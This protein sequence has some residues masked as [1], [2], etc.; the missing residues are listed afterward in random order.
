MKSEFEL[1]DELTT[2]FGKPQPPALGIGDDAAVF[3]AP[4]GM[5]LIWT[6][7][8]QI[9]NIHFRWNWL[10]PEQVG[11]R[12]ACQSLSDIAAMGG[13]PKYAMIS[14]HVPRPLFSKQ[15]LL[16]ICKG[17]QE[18][19]QKFHVQ[20]L[21]GNISQSPTLSIE[22]ALIGFIQSGK[23]LSRANAQVG[24]DVYVTGYP[25]SCAAALHLFKS[26]KGMMSTL[27][28]G[29]QKWR[30]PSPR[31]QE[32]LKLVPLAHAAIDI[33]DGV[34]QDANHIAKASQVTLDFYI[35]KFPC[36]EFLKKAA[37]TLEWPIEKFFFEPSDDYELLFTA[38]EDH[39]IKIQKDFGQKVTQV[40]KVIKGPGKVRIF[41][42]QREISYEGP[43]G[44][45]HF[46][47]QYVP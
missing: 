44:W 31:I 35:D 34:F 33:S 22:T 32:G 28:E 14:F 5:E 4:K 23:A 24:D 38:P 26:E 41:Q 9:E 45:D 1:I 2:I 17:M 27:D 30:E 29:I 11:K 20:V 13:Q 6:T 16:E 39:H 7:D 25:G 19:F 21:G 18:C 43:Y 46:Q 47:T 8:T 10:K 42:N 37:K 15:T 40:G 3:T 36:S 12:A